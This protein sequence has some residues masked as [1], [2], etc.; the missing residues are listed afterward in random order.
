MADVIHKAEDL[1]L[2]GPADNSSYTS[3]GNTSEGE[4][5]D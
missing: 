2:D 4:D 5:N 3:G 1:I